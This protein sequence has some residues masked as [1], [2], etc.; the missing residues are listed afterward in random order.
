ML[1]ALDVS[2]THINWGIF[3]GGELRHHWHTATDQLATEDEYGVLLHRLL[4]S[5]GL[6]LSDLK[7]VAI[8]SVV[9]PLMATLQR[10]ARNYLHLEPFVIGPGIK[11][12]MPIRYENPREVGANRIAVAVAAYAKY[13]GPVIVVD[14]NTAIVF[15]VISGLGEYLGGAILPGFGIATEALFQR[16]AKLPR[17]EL[18]PPV[19]AIGKDTEAAMRAGIVY[20]FAGAVDGLVRRIQAEL[21]P[22][23][24]VVATGEQAELLARETSTLQHVDRLLPLWGLQLVWERNRRG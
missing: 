11:M 24:Q 3:D 10:L 1:L 21:S 5:A 14:C 20:T 15:D 18:A 23:C 12:G 4:A 2:N 19:T 22:D 7:A 13:G 9:P 8:A 16:A 17:I 6:Q